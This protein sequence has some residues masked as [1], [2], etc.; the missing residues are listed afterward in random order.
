M[1]DSQSDLTKRELS[2]LKKIQNEIVYC[3]SDFAAGRFIFGNEKDIDDLLDR[4]LV[5]PKSREKILENLEC[6]TCGNKYFDLSSTVGVR[7]KYEIQLDDL[8]KD[9]KSKY[10][11]AFLEL[12]SYHDKQSLALNTKI[13]R[14][15]LKELKLN[16][17]N[18]ISVQGVFYRGR[19]DEGRVL[20]STD[21]L[22][23]PIGL[24]NEGRYNNNGLPHLYMGDSEHTAIVETCQN[25]DY[26]IN[27]YI[28]EFE[29]KTPVLNILDLSHDYL[30]IGLETPQVIVSLFDFI[31]IKNRNFKNYK[32]DYFITR[33]ITDCAKLVG[34]NGIKYNSALTRTTKNLVL[35]SIPSDLIP[36]DNPK[37]IRAGSKTTFSAKIVDW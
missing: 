15:I 3:N 26:D 10:Y 31:S 36:I 16:L 23:P 7:S 32:P 34:Y 13:G 33:F 2:Q 11:K 18:S 8:Y 19:R 25:L 20:T 30:E 5:E 37:L 1:E 9:S 28:Q 4:F 24:A 21:M 12:E 17:Q 27:V 29:L 35:F 6:P 14:K 22:L